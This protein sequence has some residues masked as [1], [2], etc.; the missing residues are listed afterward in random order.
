M[1]KRLCG[2]LCVMAMLLMMGMTVCAVDAEKIKK[3]SVLQTNSQ[4]ELREAP[5]ENS[6]VTAT[7]L[8]GTPVI[9][10]EE[11]ADGWCK[12][13]YQ[14]K[15]GYVQISYLVLLGTPIAPDAPADT[16]AE[17]Q[18]TEGEAASQPA[19]TAAGP[20]QPD[21]EAAQQPTD[22]AA[23]ESQPA[24]TAAEPQPADV[25]T[26]PQAADNAV[27]PDR[28]ALDDE[29]KTIEE[30]AIVAYQ[31]AETAKDQAASEKVWGIVI[32]V[33]VVAI[34]AVGIITTLRNNKGKK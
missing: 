29:F 20:Q 28:N 1:K 15:E 16:T 11:A 6:A 33:L 5:D 9:I 34:F 27:R 32:A 24:D 8:G 14:E 17:P 23:A 12:A 21:G 19:D 25:E 13:A 31:E 10:K 18:Q 22:T 4:V 26:A 7:L 2:I 3:N 30:A